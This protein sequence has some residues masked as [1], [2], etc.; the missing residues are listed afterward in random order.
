[1][2]TSLSLLMS[3][4]KNLTSTGVTLG[5]SLSS[6]DSVALLRCSA[7][8][9]HTFSS[10]YPIGFLDCPK[11]T[12]HPDVLRLMVGRNVLSVGKAR[13][14]SDWPTCSLRTGKHREHVHLFV[15]DVA[16]FICLL[17]LVSGL[18]DTPCLML[19]TV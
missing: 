15:V 19:L 11:V 6:L 3:P 13:I 12:S 10:I 1:M 4:M 7:S 2:V 9:L 5:H 18:P 8:F 14:L 16:L 17:H